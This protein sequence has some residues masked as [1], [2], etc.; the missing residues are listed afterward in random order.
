MKNGIHA[1]FLT[2][3]KNKFLSRGV[4]GDGF[5]VEATQIDRSIVEQVR[6][7]SMTSDARLWMLLRSV[8]YLVTNRVPGHFVECG[9]WQGGSMMAVAK[10]LD[11]MNDH[12]RELWL[13]DTFSGMTDPSDLDVESHSGRSAMELLAES[14]INNARGVW[15]YSLYEDVYANMM[16]TGYPSEKLRFIKGKVEE[17]LKH[18]VPDQIA[19]LRLDTDWY[20]ST[21]AELE[22]LY[23]KLV[24]NGVCIID[25]YGHWEGARRAF[26][27]F[28]SKLD[29]APL[30]VPIDYT[31]R[32][33][34]K[35]FS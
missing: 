22:I 16:K 5:P 23:D 8:E 4:S 2:K 7:Y 11:A 28:V 3:V 20:E 31:G 14:D 33:F 25:D 32:M 13:Y 30:L 12:T 21:R 27:E 26:D 1:S 9:V 10:K 17:T 24:M 18:H 19:L 15:A 29:H 34:I 35:T 6:S